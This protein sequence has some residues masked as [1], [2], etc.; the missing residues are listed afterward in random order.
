MK[1]P[2]NLKLISIFP[3]KKNVKTS[4]KKGIKEQRQKSW[5]LP[6]VLCENAFQFYLFLVDL[7]CIFF[8]EFQF[9]I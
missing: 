7:F 1:R 4:C 5:V 6:L 8:N 2:Q 3:L 9:D